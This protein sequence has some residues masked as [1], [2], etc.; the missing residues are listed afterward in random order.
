MQDDATPPP[1]NH[2]S[3]NPRPARR[4]AARGWRENLRFAMLP[5]VAAPLLFSK[6]ASATQLSAYAANDPKLVGEFEKWLGCPVDFTMAFTDQQTWEAIGWPQWF[7]DQFKVLDKPTLWSVAMIPKRSSLR[8]AATG[9]YNRYYVSAARILAKSKPFPDGTIRIRLGWEM[10]GDWFPWAARGKEEDFIKTFRHIVNSFRSV[11]DDFRFEWN[12]NYG[13][14]MDVVKAYP[15]DAYVDIV[16]MDFYWKPEYVGNDPVR[17]FEII[18]DHRVGLRWLEEF[19]TARGKRTAY[20]E[21]GVRGDNAGPF[22][23]LLHEWIKANPNVLYAN[24]WNHDADYP[25]LL[26]TNR[27]PRTGAAF[28][29]AFCPQPG[30]VAGVRR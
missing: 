13:Q 4:P 15:G 3:M 6:P 29:Q 24:Y 21:W 7:V 19:A 9:E 25:G 8:E 2:P 14:T 17:A 20:S 11:S 22:I 5:L 28:K 27:W 12:V 30:R 1:T 26:S 18:R 10:N 16:G 23:R